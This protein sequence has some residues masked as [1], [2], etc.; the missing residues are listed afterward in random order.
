MFEALQKGP[1][2]VKTMGQDLE[3]GY[4][5]PQRPVHCH[6]IALLV[7]AYSQVCKISIYHFEMVTWLVWI[8]SASHQLTLTT[9]RNYLQ[10][11]RRLLYYRVIGMTTMFLML[12][13]AVALSG[14]T[15]S[16]DIEFTLDAAA[17]C[18]W[19]SSR[20]KTWSADVVF[21]VCVLTVGFLSR[22]VKLFDNPSRVAKLWLRTK[23]GGWL[24]RQCGACLRNAKEASNWATKT[25][26]KLLTAILIAV[27][28]WIKAIYEALGSALAELLWI[29]FN[30]FYG[31][32]KVFSW[33]FSTTGIGLQEGEW[34]FGQT[35]AILMLILPLMAITEIH[36][37]D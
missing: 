26:W 29:S 27:Y 7:T 3:Q 25:Y 30:L 33:R 1:Y 11:N 32:A 6:C 20:L 15:L 10:E 12:F 19:N 37:G 16:G 18:A 4:H 24:K 21:S 17:R 9:M 14:A 31:T 23:P 35:V 28:I 13:V 34:T 36:S 22:L 5:R 2:T 8:A